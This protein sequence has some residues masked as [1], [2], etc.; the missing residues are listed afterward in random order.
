MII[1]S[2]EVI[3]VL[4]FVI[5]LK[6]IFYSLLEALFRYLIALLWNVAKESQCLFSFETSCASWLGFLNI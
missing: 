4:L 5:I 2:L 1:A 3:I 6:F